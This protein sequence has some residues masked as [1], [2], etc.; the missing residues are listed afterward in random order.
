[1]EHLGVINTEGGPLLLADFKMAQLWRGTDNDSADYQRACT[2]FD[3]NPAQEGI[4]I[5]IADGVGILWEMGGAGTADV[6]RINQRQ[7]VVVRSWL[8]DPQSSY[9][10]EK[11]AS[12]PAKG[13]LE[14][15]QIVLTSGA[16]SIFWAAEDGRCFRNTDLKARR[17]SGETSVEESAL[18]VQVENRTYRCQHD[19]IEMGCGTARRVHLIAE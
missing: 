18:I 10:I 16:L 12:S 3:S 9:D 2:L 11:L 17:P 15:G 14:I 13:F 8:N 4:A 1:M 6:F 7:I 5:S 19:Q